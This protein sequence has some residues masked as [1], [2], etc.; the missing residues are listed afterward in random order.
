MK[1]LVDWIWLSTPI[2]TVRLEINNKGIVYFVPPI[3]KWTKGKHYEDVLKYFKN[4]FLEELIYKIYY[5]EL[6]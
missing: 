3:V 2:Y 6:Q 1:I 4:R 5:K